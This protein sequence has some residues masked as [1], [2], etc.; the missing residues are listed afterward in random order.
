MDLLLALVTVGTMLAL[1]AFAFFVLTR[2][3]K[4]IRDLRGVTTGLHDTLRWSVGQ[5]A[6]DRCA[7]SRDRPPG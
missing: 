4:M 2:M 6:A 7:P 5:I 3:L 1:G